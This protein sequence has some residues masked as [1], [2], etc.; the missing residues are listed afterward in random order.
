MMAVKTKL[1]KKKYEVVRAEIEYIPI[2]L[3]VL[4]KDDLE[5]IAAL[6]EKLESNPDVVQIYDNIECA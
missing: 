3:A 4:D 1:E 2:E 6:Y 5:K